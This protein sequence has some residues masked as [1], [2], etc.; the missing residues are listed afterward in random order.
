MGA[1]MTHE[2]QDIF[3]LEFARYIAAGLATHPQ[4][5]ALAL[6]NL[7]NWERR[8]ADAPQLLRCYREW[9]EL[10]ALPDAEFISQLLAQTDR[11]QEIRQGTPFAGIMTAREVWDIKRR[12]R[13]ELSLRASQ[14]ADKQRGAA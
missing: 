10:L 2:A 6:S 9:R 11:G 3:S 14:S 5:R 1:A 4:W 7:D 8:N 12:I 13:E